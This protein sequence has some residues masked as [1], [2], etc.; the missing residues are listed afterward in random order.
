MC[1][2]VCV[3]Q[4][5]WGWNFR[6]FLYAETKATINKHVTGLQRRHPWA[7]LG[8]G[9]ATA[10]WW[11]CVYIHPHRSCRQSVEVQ[12]ES[13][14]MLC[15]PPGTED[16][17]RRPCKELLW[18]HLPV[19]Y[20]PPHPPPPTPTPPALE[21]LMRQFLLA[22]RVLMRYAVFCLVFSEYLTAL[23]YKHK[24]IKYKCYKNIKYN[25]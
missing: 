9:S 17:V 8:S 10:P 12:P 14:L 1:V 21:V 20:L 23:I 13:C 4:L 18:V 2:C 24:F 6:S 22:S 15:D 11:P 3:S 25:F 19:I 5:W 16:N 7:M